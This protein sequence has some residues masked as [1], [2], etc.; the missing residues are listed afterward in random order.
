MANTVTPLAGTEVLQVQGIAQNGSPSGQTF[1]VTTAQMGCVRGFGTFVATG[2]AA[3]TVTNAAIDTTHVVIMSLAVVGGT[4]GA[5]PT[6]QTITAG[7]SFT[8][9]ATALDTSTYNYK[10]IQ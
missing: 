9:A 6:V 2:T 1:Q 5:L 8:V 7:T 10:I 4:V 3:V